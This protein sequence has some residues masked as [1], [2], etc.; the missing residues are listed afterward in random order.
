MN[1]RK[2]KRPSIINSWIV[3]AILFTIH[4]S[5]FISPARAQIGSWRNHLAYSDIQQIVKAEDNL[6]VRASNSLYQYN[7]TDKS[8]TTYDKV[9][10]LSDTDIT[11]IGWNK[12]AKRLVAVYSNSNIDLIDT[13][14]NV[15][16]VSALYR[17]AMTEDKTID[18]LTID[19]VYAYLYA[20]FG[21]VK[22]NMQRAE[23]S[24]TYTK[25]H[26]EYPT[27][28][29]VST[30]NSDWDQYIDVV[31]TLKPGGPKYNYFHQLNFHQNKLYTVGGGFYQFGNFDRPG[32]IQV[33]D[34]DNEWTIYQED[35]KPAFAENFLD[36][37]SIAVDP[38]DQNHV[39][40]SSCSGLYEFQNGVFVKNYTEGNTD[41]FTSVVAD[42]PQ[43]VRTNGVV[44]DNEGNLYC[45]NSGSLYGIIKW[46]K[47]GTWNGIM[48]DALIDKNN[49]AM[50]GMKGSFFDSRGLMWF[51]NAHSDNPYLFCYDPTNGKVVKYNHFINQDGINIS[52]YA[53]EYACED[54]DGNIW[55]A[56]NKGP[57]YLDK[58]RIADNTLG[59]I[60][61]KVPRND[62]TD[63]ADYLLSNL[64]INCIA[65]DGAN[66]KW[67]GT[68]TNGVFLIS[69]D[70]NTQIYHFTEENS[71]LLS[72]KIASIAINDLTGEV[73]FGT[74]KGLCS[75][76]S[77][78]TEPESEMTK[79]NV[80][81]YP[82]PVT[83]D[84]TGLIT[85][86]GLSYDADVKIVTSNGALVNQGRSNGGIY[87]WDGCDRKGRRVASGIYMVITATNDGSKGTVCKIAVI[88]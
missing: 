32:I 29:P 40:A 52:N 10:G 34:N 8:I 59:V 76:M 82:N 18:S 83:P 45:L 75:F 31:K 84:Y 5:L 33:L 56:T 16:N 80:W 35:I 43:Y 61:Y 85:I 86:K 46:N 11:L 88:R 49:K 69:A 66:R 23:I 26:P 62:G 87:T 2:L 19:D 77:D 60:Q 28:L 24:D 1:K 37:T 51:V 81:A 22:L 74:D 38:Y 12:K 13:N 42:N 25:D 71:H 58:E 15:T 47:D 7:L 39:V 14:G 53:T 3:F 21:I 27:N 44:F 64:Y 68:E 36:V 79:D 57:V 55:I 78:A 70:N 6:F 4:F 65:V 17:K 63:Y 54:R 30:I 73:F 20:P 48:D 72:N 67:F 50:R 41:Y 9:N